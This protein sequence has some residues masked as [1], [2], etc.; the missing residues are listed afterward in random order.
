MGYKTFYTN[1]KDHQ[2]ILELKESLKNNISVFAGCSGVGKST[3]LN[4][5][6]GQNVMLEGLI[7]NKLERGKHTTKHVELFQIDENSYIA[8]TPG[9]SAYDLEN[10]S[11]L[12]VQNYYNDFE[13]YIPN[14]RYIGCKHYLEGIS[15]CGVKK[16]VEEQLIDKNRY[17]RYCNII[18]KLLEKEARK[19]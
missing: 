7:S 14:C 12:N 5:I 6:I 19:Y 1:A 9:F 16:A 15:D 17:D 8:D 13:E 2:N 3:L 18:K 11:S 10:V 4:D